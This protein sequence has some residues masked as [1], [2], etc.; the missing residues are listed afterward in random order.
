ME[1][2]AYLVLIIFILTIFS[3]PLAIAL[4]SRRLV[5]FLNS[6]ESLLWTI[7]NVIRKIIHLLAITVGSLLG[8]SLLS[9]G[10][11]GP[12]LI[13]AYAIVC[14]YIALRREYF[15][16]FH[17]LATIGNKLGL[18]K[19]GPGE[20]GPQLKWKRNGRSSGNDGHGPGG[21]H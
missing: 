1:S 11:T 7:A 4:T 21:Q 16:D 19:V 5:K 18:R 13:G 14:A 12:K 9:M 3:G 6:K 8:M 10:V 15:A 2:L 20:H 17:L